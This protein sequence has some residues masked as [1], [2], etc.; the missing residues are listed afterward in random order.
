MYL[1]YNFER[2]ET[3]INL[4]Q[5]INHLVSLITCLTL[6]TKLGFT[7]SQFRIIVIILIIVH[8]S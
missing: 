7:I 8:I 2:P 6:I 1:F 4:V 3:Y 5:I